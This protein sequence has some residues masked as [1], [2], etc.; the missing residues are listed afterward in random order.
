M[1]QNRKSY[2]NL[3][4]PNIEV[5]EISPQDYLNESYERNITDEFLEPLRMSKNFLKME[6]V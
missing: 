5:S 2:S 1:G 6:I 3:T 4:D